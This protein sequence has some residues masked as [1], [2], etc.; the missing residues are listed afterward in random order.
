M[1]YEE[2]AS[3]FI[4]SYGAEASTMMGTPCLRYK[5]EFF[6]MMFDRENALIIKVPEQ[7]V[8][9]L[10]QD[11]TGLEFNFTKKKFKEWIL[12]PEKNEDK[13]ERLILEALDYAK[14]AIK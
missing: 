13:Y 12:I 7:R 5:G 10:I 11:G 3:K 6:T 4:G 9:E 14:Q 8:L 2:L 1:G